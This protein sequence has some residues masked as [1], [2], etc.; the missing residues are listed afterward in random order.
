MKIGKKMSKKLLHH[1]G[2]L[3][4]VKGDLI[5]HEVKYWTVTMCSKGLIWDWWFNFVKA[6][7]WFL[8]KKKAE[9]YVQSRTKG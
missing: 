1:K 2:S 4:Y 5:I 8:S 3:W 9:K 7:A 6:K